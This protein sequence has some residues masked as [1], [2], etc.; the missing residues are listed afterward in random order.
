MTVTAT[1]ETSAGADV[2]ISYSRRDAEFVREL[3]DALQERGTSV[4]L[5]VKGIG[6]GEVF[7]VALQRAIESSAGFVF[8]ISP[9][10]AQSRHCVHE[11]ELALGLNKRIIPVVHEPVADEALPEGIRVRNWIPGDDPAAADRVASAL[12]HDRDHVRE[13]TRWGLKALE[14]EQREHD[15]SLL[16]RGSELTAAEGWLAGAAGKEPAPTDLQRQF[17]REG[18]RSSRRR[19]RRLTAVSV[20]VAA[21]S[22]VLLVFAL[23]SRGQAQEQREVATEQRNVATDQ[24][25]VATSRQLA[26]QAVS[27]FETDPQLSVLL[28][29]EA[30]RKSRTPDALAALRDALDRSPAR[31]GLPAL[32]DQQCTTGNS[33]AFAPDG[34][35][36]ALG[37]CD[38]RVR[39]VDPVTGQE[40][41]SAKVGALAVNPYY[42]PDGRSLIAAVPEGLVALDPRTLRVTKRY[43]A[44][45]IR[46]LSAAASNTYVAVT[47][48]TGAHTGWVWNRE[49]GRGRELDLIRSQGDPVSV[50]VV[51][52]RVFVSLMALQT[53]EPSRVV[54]FDAR[55]GR[56]MREVRTLGGGGS[57]SAAPDERS[58]VVA[59]SG[60]VARWT[61]PEL[62]RSV[63]FRDETMNF[64]LVRF[65]RD[66]KRLVL[67]G[68]GG[69]S[70][71]VPVDGGPGE[72]R[73]PGSS[74]MIVGAG[75][76]PDGERVAT[77]DRSG[78]AFLW[79]T[80]DMATV[81]GKVASDV[82][83]LGVAGDDVL[84]STEHGTLSI[85]EPSGRVRVQ[86]VPGAIRDNT[87]WPDV[88]PWGRYVAG[89]IGPQSTFTRVAT[90]ER[91][92]KTVISDRA[93]MQ[94]G[95][96]AFDAAGRQAAI[97]GSTRTQSEPIR[98]VDLRTGR[99]KTLP[100]AGPPCG[101]RSGVFV[102]RYLLGVSW[103]DAFVWDAASGRAAGHFRL[104]NGGGAVAAAPHGRQAAIG[105]SAGGISI[106][107]LPKGRV[108]KQLPGHVGGT[109][110]LAYSPDGR[111][112]YSLGSDGLMQVH[113]TRTWNLV[114]RVPVDKRAGVMLAARDGLL[115]AN[116][117]GTIRRYPHCTTCG[118]AGALLHEA[119]AATVRTFTDVERQTYLDG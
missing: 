22:V 89:S 115:L 98:M 117:D 39:L 79:R 4:W 25:N 62:E 43:R 3:A 20:G 103:C 44:N 10:S 87:I 65:S 16:L 82:A 116:A 9:R 63:V 93:D 34:S 42:T 58:F 38:G 60:V 52:D 67:A 17:V 28:A 8:V 41:R 70:V 30:V 51:D 96:M 83:A 84:A 37:S 113:D 13:H 26:A 109:G 110:S 81:V 23:I 106:V 94:V 107:E 40:L 24:R 78:H 101:W 118:D 68:T 99:V 104:A 29:T 102:G 48:S 91:V 73:L 33:V 11:I 12:E 15:A 27:Q 71:I 92:A 76:S 59:G 49:T 77:V 86:R 55:T 45:L 1:P 21:L 6:D 64:E 90:G 54:V 75:F 47:Q 74:E 80:V 18:F 31:A 112:L 50:A 57:L 100:G 14:W 19:Q 53:N 105:S 32:G 61:L 72:I 111:W 85:V 35:A 119:E 36:L 97:L 114:R 56:R 7:P 95:W 2:F 66:G 69:E 88:D 46:P 108:A 5:D